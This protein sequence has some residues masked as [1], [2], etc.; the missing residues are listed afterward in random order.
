MAV[1]VAGPAVAARYCDPPPTDDAVRQD[2]AL[3][4]AAVIKEALQHHRAEVALVSRSGLDLSRIGQR[5]SHAG[6]SLR[7]SALAPWAVR[8][9]YYACDE[10]RPRVFDQGLA[11]FLMGVDDAQRG[12]LS[13]VLPGAGEAALAEVARRD[14]LAVG[15]LGGSYS[16]NAHAFS[17]VHQNCNQW[18]AELLALAWGAHGPGAPAA[19]SLRETAQD[20]LRDQGYRPTSVELGAGP[21]MWLS[22]AW[23]HLHAGDHP[24]QDLRAGRY[25]VSLPAS[26]E[27]FVRQQDPGARR[28]EFCHDVRRVVV[29]QGWESLGPDCEPAEGDTVVTLD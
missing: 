9:L 24:E 19:G 10:Q 18:V 1:T 27:A 28:L 17:T 12:F 22:L 2:R 20:W 8:Q 11:A 26:L 5:Y 13:V 15:V 21:L 6:L 14:D 23:P 3:R 7:D 25:R 4:V 29:R 16:A